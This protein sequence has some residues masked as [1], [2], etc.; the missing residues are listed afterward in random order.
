MKIIIYNLFS[1]T[2]DR[3]IDWR[4]VYLIIGLAIPIA[5]VLGIKTKLLY[6]K[7]VKAYVDKR[8]EDF[9]LLSEKL[10]DKTKNKI[11]INYITLYKAII[12]LETNSI[13][14][15]LKELNSINLK[16]ILI[17]K[18]YWKAIINYY[19]EEIDEARI[20]Y[21]KMKNSKLDRRYRAKG[22]YMEFYDGSTRILDLI[23]KF[24]EGKGKEI[25][26]E[27]IDLK[28]KSNYD[29]TRELYSRIIDSIDNNKVLERPIE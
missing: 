25:R 1:K 28:S 3:S 14:Y 11:D 8:Y 16:G 12:F 10:F 26:E 15:A 6:K 13:E 4:L 5:I 17:V 7:T 20:N 22:E 9:F 23:N 18:Y 21:D 19:Y 29:I 2:V 27:F 24:Y